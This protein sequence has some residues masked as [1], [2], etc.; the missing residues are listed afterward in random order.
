[1]AGIGWDSSDMGPRGRGRPVPAL[2]QIGGPRGR[3]GGVVWDGA[4]A[5]A[6][7]GLS[8]SASASGSHWC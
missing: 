5:G 3:G 4:D 6:S 1:M 8:I 7:L 2:T